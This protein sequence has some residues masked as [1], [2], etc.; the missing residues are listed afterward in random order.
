MVYKRGTGDDARKAKKKVVSAIVVEVVKPKPRLRGGLFH[1]CDLLLLKNI[2]TQNPNIY[3][4]ITHSKC[5]FENTP[6]QYIYISIFPN[7]YIDIYIPQCLSYS[8]CKV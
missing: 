8:V 1:R 7:I 4:Y 2:S 3:I 5:S 6:K